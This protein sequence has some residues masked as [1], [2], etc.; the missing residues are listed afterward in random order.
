MCKIFA[1][2]FGKYLQNIAARSV[3]SISQAA[4]QYI[5]PLCASASNKYG[6]K[7]GDSLASITLSKSYITFSNGNNRNSS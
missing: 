1:K 7:Y 3:E 5:S 2:Y 6:D 4:I